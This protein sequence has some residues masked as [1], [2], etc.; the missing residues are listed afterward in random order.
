MRDNGIILNDCP[1]IYDSS[2]AHSIIIPGVGIDL[3]LLMRGTISNI[4]TRR[5]TDEELQKCERFELTSAAPWNPNVIPGVDL[6]DSL[7]TVQAYAVGMPHESITPPEFSQDLLSG[8]INSVRIQASEPTF[9]SPARHEADV[10]AHA[11]VDCR[12]Q[13]AL[14]A[15]SRTTVVTNE[16]LARRWFTGLES[17]SRTLLATT[18]EGMRFVEGDLEWRLR[19]SQAHLRFPTLNCVIYT[20]TMFAKC[21]SVHGYTCAQVF[22]DGHKFFHLSNA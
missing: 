19:T 22:T 7:R 6:E 15:T 12:E 3:P 8:F 16:E 13:S 5:P 17:A 14:N 20:D 9:T 2:S 1:N 21:R 18:Q 10:I 11:G 4:D